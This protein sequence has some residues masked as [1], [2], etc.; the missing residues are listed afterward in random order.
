MI[1]Q[2][3]D[4]F[5]KNRKKLHRYWP[6]IGTLMIVMMLGLVIYLLVKSPNL[7]NPF[8]VIEQIKTNSIDPR[9]LALLAAM[10]PVLTVFLLSTVLVVIIYVWAFI[11][12]EA[13]YHKII[14]NLGKP[15]VKEQKEEEHNPEEEKKEETGSEPQEEKS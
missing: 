12:L 11:I 8:L 10:C 13:R 1:N 9:T 14:D 5:L 7:I 15:E 2:E 3:D 6:A 4:K